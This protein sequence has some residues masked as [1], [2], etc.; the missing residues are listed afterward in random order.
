MSYYPLQSSPPCTHCGHG[1]ILVNIP[2]PCGCV[3]SI[4]EVCI[5]TAYLRGICPFCRKVWINI[6]AAS[7]VNTSHTVIEA[8]PERRWILYCLS[9][10]IIIFMGCVIFW[11][12]YHYF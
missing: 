9:T 6:T 4:H 10:V 1:G 12:L 3:L 2:Y 5:Q 8:R 7:S 11:L